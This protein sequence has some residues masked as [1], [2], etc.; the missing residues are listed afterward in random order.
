MLS[1]LLLGNQ[2]VNLSNKYQPYHGYG[3]AHPW[4]W[5]GGSLGYP[6]RVRTLNGWHHAYKPPYHPDHQ[7]YPKAI[8]SACCRC[9]RTHCRFCGCRYKPW[10]RRDK[11]SEGSVSEKQHLH[12]AFRRQSKRAIQR[13]LAGEEISHNFRVYGTWLD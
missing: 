4:I 5:Y 2:F 13:E 6:P 11:D 1:F 12:R 7:H 9:G 8:V 10:K 3:S